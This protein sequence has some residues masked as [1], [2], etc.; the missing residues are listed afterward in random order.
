MN[1]GDWRSRID[2]L[3]DQILN[4]LNQR[5]EAT[6]RIGDLTRRQD[7]P[8]SVPEREVPALGPPATFTQP[9]ALSRFGSAV[10]CRLRTIAAVFGKAGPTGRDKTSIPSA[11]VGHRAAAPVA[12]ALA[13]IGERTLF[14]RV[15]GPY[16]AA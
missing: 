2:D 9:A 14:L 6:L 15:L 13:E 12:Q 11:L 16:P 4:L 5:A 8:S 7:A 1:L 10:P 3:D